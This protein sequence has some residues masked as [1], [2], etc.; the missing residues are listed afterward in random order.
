MDSNLVADL[1]YRKEQC[2]GLLASSPM[3]RFHTP[4][5]KFSKPVMVNV[6]L[7]QNPAKQ[8]RPST[9]SA[10][11][12]ASE[13]P[14]KARPISAFMSAYARHGELMNQVLAILKYFFSRHMGSACHL[15]VLKDFPGW[16]IQNFL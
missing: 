6:P 8:K 12:S 11:K 3:I 9:A 1:H 14:G 15:V 5:K 10:N 13:G 4:L 16:Q 7:P 2:E